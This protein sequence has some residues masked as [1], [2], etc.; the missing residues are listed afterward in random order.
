MD[1][2]RDGKKGYPRPREM[3]VGQSVGTLP[4]TNRRRTLHLPPSEAVINYCTQFGIF[5]QST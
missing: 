4:V 1:G 5:T 2:D 3:L